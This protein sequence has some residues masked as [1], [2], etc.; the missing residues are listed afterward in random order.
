MIANSR[1]SLILANSEIDDKGSYR[2]TS[3]DSSSSKDNSSSAGVKITGSSAT[4]TNNRVHHNYW[5][6]IW[7]DLKGGPIMVT[8]NRFD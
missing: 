6:G 2:F 3:L 7:C 1:D 4:L 8:G 5:H